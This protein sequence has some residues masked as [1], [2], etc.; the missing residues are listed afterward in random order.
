[1]EVLHRAVQAA[2]VLVDM[3]RVPMAEQT[4]AAAEAV[5]IEQMERQIPVKVRVVLE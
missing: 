4:Q 2:A 1:L 3:Q 5:M